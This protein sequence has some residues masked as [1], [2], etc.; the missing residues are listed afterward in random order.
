MVLVTGPTG[1]GKT[2]TLYSVLKYLNR[3]GTNIMT[4]E[5][6]VEYRLPGINQVQINPAASLDFSMVLR[7]FLRQDPDVILIG[8]IRDSET[9]RIAAQAALTGHLV[10]ATMH[11]NNAIQAITRLVEIGVEPFLVAPSIIGV[12][13]QRL[14]RRLCPACKER[15]QLTPAE[16]ERH[17]E[18]NGT[19][20][21]FFWRARSC[22][23]CHGTGYH[24][25]LPIHEI[26]VLDDDVRRMI[27]RDAT[28]QEIQ[29]HCQKSGFRDMRYDG[30]KKV[31]RGL[32][33]I[34]EID[35]VTLSEDF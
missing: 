16:I 4:A 21:V 22:P 26:F 35:R 6:P 1:S 13:A 29:E 9:A 11:T 20:E 2:T 7:S 23:D 18:W 10:V 24:G 5:D 19:T 15:Y 25:R 17:F 34:Q 3:P 30:L 28:V 12:L 33:S 8:E 32:T 31:L 27:A 14:V